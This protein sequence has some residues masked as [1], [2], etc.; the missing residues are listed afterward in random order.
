M[1][2]LY[3]CFQPECVHP[4]CQQKQKDP[5]TSTWY[6]GG[7]PTSF[8]PFPVVD[9]SRPW[10]DQIVRNVV[11]LPWSLSKTRSHE[12]QPQLCCLSSTIRWKFNSFS[13]QLKGRQPSEDELMSVAKT[14]LLPVKL[15]LDHLQEVHKNGQRGAAKAAETRKGERWEYATEG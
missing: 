8:I 4:L 5:S 12:T 2:Y 7:P 14:V 3:C 11:V 10:E 13:C 1:L 9:V 15:C 6:T